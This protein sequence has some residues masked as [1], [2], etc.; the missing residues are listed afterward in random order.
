MS[1]QNA[2]VLAPDRAIE[3][4]Q[5]LANLVNTLY[6]K[7]MR[8]GTDY[9]VIPGTNDKPT[10]FLPG[11]EKLMRALN[12]TPQ[13]ILIHVIRDYDKP[14]FHYEY[15]CTLVDAETG[16][17]VPGGRAIGLA[18]SA[19]AKWGWRW[20]TLHRVPP[21]L[22]ASKLVMRGG[23]A[24]EFQFAIEK[25]ETTGKYGK[26]AEYWQA[27][28]DAVA[29]DEAFFVQKETKR[30][31]SP[32]YEIDMT[33]YRIP[34]DA[35]YDQ[36]NTICKIAQKR[37]LASAIKGATNSSELFNI[38]LEDLVDHVVSRRAA[39]VTIA[40]DFVEG[41]AVE[42][43]VEQPSASVR[44][45]GVQKPTQPDPLDW[46]DGLGANVTTLQ[47]DDAPPNTYT[48]DRLKVHASRNATTFL[49]MTANGTNIVTPAAALVGLQV[50]GMFVE[51]LAQGVYPLS[52]V[53]TVQADRDAAGNWENVSVQAPE[54]VLS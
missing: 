45:A 50:N 43:T 54:G 34:N 10:L 51:A 33:E 40:Q 9:G 19:E 15:E 35:V 31:M 29:A 5:L 20:V 1:Q 21:N 37:A 49:L 8:E 22:D 14:L 13:Y 17:P 4:V 27:F 2:I 44:G 28:R 48:V 3:G 41:E 46:T 39:P 11:M 6:S 23:K 42:V 53:W 36:I 47:A 32:G 25:A 30:G 12:V 38:D 24:F 16:F 18:T 7:V 26:P 52:P